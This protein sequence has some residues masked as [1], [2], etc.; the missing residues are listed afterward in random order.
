MCEYTPSRDNISFQNLN[1]P[2]RTEPKAR[3]TDVLISEK[4][5][6]ERVT[7]FFF[8]FFHILSFNVEQ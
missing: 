6:K 8:S 4:G 2:R 7:F 5:K 3:M 1:V